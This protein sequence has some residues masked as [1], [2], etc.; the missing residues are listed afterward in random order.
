MVGRKE[1]IPNELALRRADEC[2]AFRGRTSYGRTPPK[3]EDHA[4]SSGKTVL[5]KGTSLSI[6]AAQPRAIGWAV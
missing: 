4:N 6:E 3:R 5:R 1:G 2:P